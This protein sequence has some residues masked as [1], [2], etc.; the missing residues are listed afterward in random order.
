MLRHNKEI[1]ALADKCAQENGYFC[2]SYLGR[3]GEMF[4]YEPCERSCEYKCTDLPSV[5]IVEDGKAEYVGWE[6]SFDILN[7]LKFRDYKKGRGI[8]REYERKVDNNDFISEKEQEYISEIV[9]NQR[10]GYDVPVPKTDLYKYLE[11]AD[12]LNMKI[13]LKTYKWCKDRNDGWCYYLE[14]K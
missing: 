6:R 9:N 1:Q 7:G 10:P 3:K 5:I 14:L 11:I 2:S 8:F 13:E 4:V 12:R